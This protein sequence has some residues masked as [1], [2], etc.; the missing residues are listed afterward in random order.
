M[1]RTTPTDN[2]SEADHICYGLQWELTRLAYFQRINDTRRAAEAQA[3]ADQWKAK[4]DLLWQEA[5]R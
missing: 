3:L 4:R 2:R 1:R 5:S